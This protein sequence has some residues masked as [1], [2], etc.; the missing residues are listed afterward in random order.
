MRTTI[1]ILILICSR[2]QVLSQ[3]SWSYKIDSL[4]EKNILEH[5]IKGLSIG[6]VFNDNIQYSKGFGKLNEKSNEL[7]S[8]ETPFL[9]ASIS[10]VFVATAVIQLLERGLLDI[11]EKVIKY[12]PEFTMK[13]GRYKEITVKQLLNHTS[14]L[15]EGSPY[16][17][18]KMKNKNLDIQNYTL[19]LSKRKLLFKP[20]EKFSYSNTG[21]VVLG[22]LLEKITNQNFANYIEDNI[23]KQANMSNSHFDMFYFNKLLFPKYNNSKGKIQECCIGNTSPSG[24]LISTATDLSKWILLNLLLHNSLTTNDSSFV[25]KESQT[26]LWTPTQTFEESKTTLGLGWWQYNSEKYGKSVFHSGHYTNYSVSNLVIFPGQN[27]GF[28]ILCNDESA[29]EVVYNQLTDGI[30]EIVLNLLKE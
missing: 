22:Y 2:V 30:T 13:D 18:D 1:I 17:W 27:F 5:N 7:I 26:L 19:S 10:K 20:G 12:I 23:L 4:L 3:N 29:K 28:V 15:S 6:I 21:Y 9:A 16:R 25:T 14:G 24:N 11:N 8:V